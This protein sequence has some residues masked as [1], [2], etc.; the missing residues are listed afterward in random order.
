MSSPTKTIQFVRSDTGK[1]NDAKNKRIIG[2]S[3]S[4]RCSQQANDQGFIQRRAW[5]HLSN[6]N[7]VHRQ[8]KIGTWLYDVVLIRLKTILHFR[9]Q[10]ICP[11]RNCYVCTVLWRFFCCTT[12]RKFDR[13]LTLPFNINAN[14]GFNCQDNFHLPT[15]ELSCSYWPMHRMKNVELWI[16]QEA[17]HV[18][19]FLAQST[20]QIEKS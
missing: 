14:G 20:E 7:S 15:Q 11:R 16:N 3:S 19:R 13:P 12:S 18:F 1:P 6:Q 4:A 10:L 2:D 8:T 9:A 5:T 17:W